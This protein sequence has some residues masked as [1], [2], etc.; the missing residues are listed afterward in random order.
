M[1]D[2]PKLT[3]G[4]ERKLAASSRAIC[5]S[6]SVVFAATSFKVGMAL[7]LPNGVVASVAAS[8]ISF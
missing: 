1:I 6:V 7:V 3:L 5:S 4:S 8:R 2:L